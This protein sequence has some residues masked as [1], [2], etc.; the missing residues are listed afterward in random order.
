MTIF[1]VNIRIKSEGMRVLSSSEFI[2]STS[3][4][5]MYM[6]FVYSLYCFKLSIVS[7]INCIFP[8]DCSIS[9]AFICSMLINEASLSGLVISLRRFARMSSKFADIL[10]NSTCRAF[11][12]SNCSFSSMLLLLLLLSSVSQP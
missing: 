4:V 1:A 6:F 10:H 9:S 11:N 8:Y 7:F 2:G 5:C 3:Y 12:T